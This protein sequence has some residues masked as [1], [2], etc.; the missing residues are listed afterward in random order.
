MDER[1]TDLEINYMHLEQT[2]Q[3]LNALVYRQQQAIDRLTDEVQ[4]LKEQLLTVAPSL[5]ASPDEE[6]PP[7]HY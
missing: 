5:V 7:P 2:V 6:G 1:L 4:G 3:D